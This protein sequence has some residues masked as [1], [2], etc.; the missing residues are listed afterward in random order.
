MTATRVRVAVPA[1]T[2][3]EDRLAGSLTFRHAAYLAA[4]AAGVAVMLLGDPAAGRV[5]A[6]GFLAVVGV[7][8]AVVRP[9]G[10]PLDRMLPAFVAYV[11][12][13]RTRR[14]EPVA[15]PPVAD[16]VLVTGDDK[17]ADD[18]PVDEVP[19]PPRRR[20]RLDPAVV[21]R[22]AV[23]LAVVAVTALAV[24]RIADRPP[25][26]TEPRVVVV[27][28]VVPEPDPWKEVDDAVDAWLDAFLGG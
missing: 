18:E 20:R 17:P 1:D 22:G 24:E 14:H 27:P 5:V 26:P 6:G 4:A 19:P 13:R 15:P 12:R 7:V 10:E 23:A 11:A 28:V 8:G 25:R 3:G 2:G 16:D 9:Y 21:R